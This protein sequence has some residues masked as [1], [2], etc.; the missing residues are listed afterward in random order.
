M[1]YFAGQGVVALVDTFHA[2][3]VKLSGQIKA[4]LFARVVLGYVRAGG[5]LADKASLVE[6]FDI[7]LNDGCGVFSS[8]R[9][10]SQVSDILF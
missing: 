3:G 9:M 2:P 8:M 1:F 10:S 7:G 6:V 5:K 4:E